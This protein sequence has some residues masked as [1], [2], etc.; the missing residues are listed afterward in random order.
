MFVAINVDNLFIMSTHQG[1]REHFIRYLGSHFVVE[2]LGL[3][4]WSL[5]MRINQ[6]VDLGYTSIDQSLYTEQ[7]LK[8]EDFWTES[9]ADLPCVVANKFDEVELYEIGSKNYF[10]IKKRGV[11]RVAGKLFYLAE[12]TRPDIKAACGKLSMYLHNPHETHWKGLV[13][14]AKYLRG[15]VNKGLLYK[16]GVNEKGERNNSD[17][18][19]FNCLVGY[20]DSDWAGYLRDRRSRSGWIV[21]L[22]GCVIAWFSKL[23]ANVA[24]SSTEAELIAAQS[25]VMMILSCRKILEFLGFTP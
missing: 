21:M 24:C 10:D 5:G 20:V 11:R 23:Q 4:K 14:L 13:H 3:L 12:N 7:V 6:R 16:R 1:L 8:D 22:N 9:P 2:D 17:S 15:T 19:L 18:I 25:V